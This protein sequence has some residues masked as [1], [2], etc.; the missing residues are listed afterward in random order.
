MAFGERG[1]GSKWVALIGILAIAALALWLLWP[2]IT[3][4]IKHERISTPAGYEAELMTNPATGELFKTIKQ[5]NPAEFQAF[6]T[7]GAELVKD[8]ASERATEGYARQFMIT[9]LRDQ[10]KLL[11]AAPHDELLK[12]V[13]AQAEMIGK[14]RA[15]DM[16][17]CAELASTGVAKHAGADLQ[18]AIDKA[19]IVRLHTAAAGRDH[20]VPITRASVSD[21]DA[22]IAVMRKNGLSESDAIL[23]T[24][25]ANAASAPQR[26]QCEIVYQS[27]RAALALPKDQGDRVMRW[28]I[29]P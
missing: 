26:S 27:Y 21:R 19:A 17:T 8:G 22:L 6:V 28:L 2:T 23:F 5:T 16:A 4:A 14:A 20:P 10:P 13:N 1:G 15:A 9:I 24:T 25:V 18:P 3:D 11:A 12:A 29:G 7:R